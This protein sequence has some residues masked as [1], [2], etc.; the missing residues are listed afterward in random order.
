[1][2]NDDCSVLSH[3]L[4][5]RHVSMIS[6]GGVIG[7][8]LFVGSSAAI[9]N[10]GPAVIFS[11]LSAGIVAFLMMRMLG[12]MAVS[13]PGIGSFV[14]YT[15]LGLGHWA[16]FVNGWLYW[17]FWVV[18]VS[19]ET[20]AGAR[21]ISGWISIPT[22]AVDLGLLGAMTASNLFSVKVF[23]EF[24]FWFASIK[25]AAIICFM[26]LAAIF[27]CTS[28]GAPAIGFHNL[29]AHRGFA[30]FGIW[31]VLAAVPVVVF[32]ITGSE[33]ATIAAAESEAPARNVANATRTVV[34]RIITFYVGSVFLIVC[35]TPW[36]TLRGGESPFVAAM[37]VMHIHGAAT[38]MTAIVLTAVLSCMNSGIYVTSRIV[39][40][41]ARHGDAPGWL[42]KTGP[43][44]VPRRAILTGAVFS[45]LL[46]LVAIASPGAVFNFLLNASGTLIL[47]IYI[48][49]GAAQIKLRR[50]LDLELGHAPEFRMYGFPWL[51]YFTIGAVLAIIVALGWL[52]QTRSQLIASSA[53]LGVTVAAYYF[54]RRPRLTMKAQLV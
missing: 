37:T 7:A 31:A 45:Y 20:I 22:W 25:V 50:K 16:G 26:V 23:G 21:L 11:Y 32:S 30:P 33:V 8:G 35:I 6:L 1:M 12:E 39:F 47:Y 17:Y 44:K 53:S 46:A 5:P 49:I 15:R 48:T 43:R 14:E 28:H 9:L 10:A 4:R 19:A 52:P 38:I 51:S 13:R 29:T 36:D 54:F 2:S 18:V 34:L 24:E 42:V 27:L 3:S 41:L 40:E